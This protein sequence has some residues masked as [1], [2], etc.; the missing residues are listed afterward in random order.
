MREE[1]G[2]HRTPRSGCKLRA[3]VKADKTS[4]MGTGMRAGLA[5][6]QW[7]VR[8]E[9]VVRRVFV[10][11]LSIEMV[12]LL[13]DLL[14]NFFELL[15]TRS[16]QHIFNVAREESLGTWFSVSQMAIV[17]LVLL[18]L[19]LSSLR[20]GQRPAGL[21]W[22]LFSAFFL[23]LSADDAAKIHERLGGYVDTL[24]SESDEPLAAL[25]WIQGYFPSYA[26]Q[27]VVAPFF[28]LMG[29]AL[30]YFV[31]NRL[32][33]NRVRLMFLAA[34]ACWG[35]AVM[36]DF[37]EGIDGLF[38]GWAEALEV[39]KYTVS[40]PILMTEEFLEM[41]GATLFLCVFLDCLVRQLAAQGVR[42]SFQVTA[43]ST[44]NGAADW[45]RRNGRQER[46]REL[47]W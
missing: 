8:P 15:P 37:I 42:V 25:A 24:V 36:L 10:F 12:L 18:V 21:G 39:K 23:F 46:E 33:G 31:W 13:L 14:F 5:R 1:L 7:V 35:V 17:G 27:W 32:A 29:L 22:G 34:F 40:H 38:A 26:W 28:A 11:C 2:P 45:K 41:L 3:F 30:L 16:L 4:G 6:D 9:L 43:S 20:A 47:D 19:S 44:I